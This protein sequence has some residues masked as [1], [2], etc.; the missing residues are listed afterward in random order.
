MTTRLAPRRCRTLLLC[1]LILTTSGATATR[2]E[3][4]CAAPGGAHRGKIVDYGWSLTD[5]DGR[6]F[7]IASTQGQ[8]TVLFFGFARCRGVCPTLLVK[9]A[10]AEAELGNQ[11]EGVGFVMVSVDGDNDRPENMKALMRRY[12]KRFVGLTAPP[13]IVAP[14]A[15]KYGVAFKSSDRPGDDGILHSG[16]I[17]LLNQQACPVQALPQ[18]SSAKALAKAIRSH[19]KVEEQ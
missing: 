7:A 16:H 5:Q 17:V 19:N 6:E 11:A 2:G 13:D 3:L 14:I 4:L 15:K 18:E 8:V 9:M 1:L 12:S 10:R